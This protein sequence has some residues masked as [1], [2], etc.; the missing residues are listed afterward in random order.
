MSTL[1][2]H[3]VDAFVVIARQ[4]GSHDIR[5]ERRVDSIFASLS[6]D[7]QQLLLARVDEVR[8]ANPRRWGAGGIIWTCEHDYFERDHAELISSADAARFLGLSYSAF[9]AHPARHSQRALE[10]NPGGR[11]G[12]RTMWFRR[13][14]LWSFARQ[15]PRL[16]RV[17]AVSM[18]IHTGRCHLH[19][20]CL[21]LEELGKA[22]WL[23][24]REE[25]A[26]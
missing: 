14:V 8:R 24:A 9:Q 5:R 11:P 10:W 21:E 12:Q 20:D 22:C 17:A 15:T 26:A 6:A 4:F 25:A 16:A 7:E 1:P 19:D 2:R 23:A 3:I 13:D 18:S